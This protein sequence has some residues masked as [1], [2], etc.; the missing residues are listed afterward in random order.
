MGDRANVCPDCGDGV[1]RRDFLKAAAGAAAAAAAG[2]PLFAE[3]RPAAA[4]GRAPGARPEELVKQ[5][6]KSLSDKQR[7]AVCFA[8][9]HPNRTKVSNNW[10]IVE[11]QIGTFFNGDQQQ[12]VKDIFRGVTSEGWAERWQ[13]QM[14]DDYGGIEKYHV[15]IFGDPSKDKF[16]WVLTGRHVTIRCD[17]DSEPG[18]AFG[19]P[20][21]YGHAAE[22]FNEKPDHPGN[23]FWHQA[24]LANKVFASFDG[25]QR[26]KALLAKS[27]PDEAKSIRLRKAGEWDGIPVAELSKDQKALV[28]ETMRELLAPY[29]ASDVEEAMKYIREAGG[30][31]KLHLAFYKEGNLGDDEIWDRWMLQ[32]PAMAWYF[33]GSPHVHTWV[34]IASNQT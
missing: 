8:W 28:E 29:R 7:G 25:K 16:E 21:F 12:L 17:G 11:P 20:I 34:N 23:V 15:A 19:G 32:G 13:K 27:P 10:K 5:L 31:D 9:D 3:P 33:R 22:G 6:C 2:L 30:L 24:R 18:V 4:A 26:E 1:D 14:R